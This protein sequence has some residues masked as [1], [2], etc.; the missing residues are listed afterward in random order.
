R[1]SAHDWVGALLNAGAFV[2]VLT[3]RRRAAEEASGYLSTLTRA[4]NQRRSFG[5]SEQLGITANCGRPYP[6]FSEQ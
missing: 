4:Q 3:A 5:G 6:D 2:S 1:L